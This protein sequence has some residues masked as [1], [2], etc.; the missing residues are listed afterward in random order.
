MH[1]GGVM[2]HVHML[3]AKGVDVRLRSKDKAEA[4]VKA[5]RK[6]MA[7]GASS[8]TPKLS[9]FKSL[10]LSKKSGSD[11][12]RETASVEEG[13]SS[14]PALVAADGLVLMLQLEDGTQREVLMDECPLALLRGE[15]QGR[16]SST[17]NVKLVPDRELWFVPAASRLR[18]ASLDAP[19]PVSPPVSPVATSATSVFVFSP[20]PS[21]VAVASPSSTVDVRSV[22]R[23]NDALLGVASVGS[24]KLGSVDRMLAENSWLTTVPTL[25]TFALEVVALDDVNAS[26]L[27]DMQKAQ[28]VEAALRRQAPPV[29]RLSKP[30]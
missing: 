13:S 22:L 19:S 26:S 5:I 1:K 21:P 18:A 2:V 27:L 12:H 28:K 24:N 20:P 6:A 10:S 8:S 9:R 17:N 23:L 29:N 15:A 30:V 7:K 14:S 3:D 25:Y 16:Q 11:L 4:A